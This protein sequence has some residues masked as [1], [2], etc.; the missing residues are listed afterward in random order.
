MAMIDAVKVKDTTTKR[1]LSIKEA[2]T[3]LG[4]SIWSVRELIWHGDLPTIKL[5]YGSERRHVRIDTKD[6]ETFITNNKERNTL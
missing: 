2:A 1:L 5:G 4:I 6:L 3:Y